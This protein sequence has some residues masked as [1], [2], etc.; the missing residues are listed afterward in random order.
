MARQ[1]EVKVAQ[2]RSQRDA[3]R[4]I[5]RTDSWKP[6]VLAR[7]LSYDMEDRKRQAQM[8]AVAGLGEEPGF[9][10]RSA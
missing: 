3:A 1:I 9:S 2:P 7:R 5:R 4:A 8:H 6:A 10:E